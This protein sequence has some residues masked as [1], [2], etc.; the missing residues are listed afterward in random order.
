MVYNA[1]QVRQILMSELSD[2]DDSR[3]DVEASDGEQSSD[4]EEVDV[5]EN[6]SKAASDSECED[7]AKVELNQGTTYR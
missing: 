4:D 1:A 6:F 5:F 7:S 2:G 3:D